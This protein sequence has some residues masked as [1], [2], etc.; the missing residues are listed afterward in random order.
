M[1]LVLSLSEPQFPHLSEY[2]G[3]YQGISPLALL[4]FGCREEETVVCH[5]ECFPVPLA[6]IQ[7]C[8]N[9][10]SLE[11]I[12]P[13]CMRAHTCACECYIFYGCFLCMCLVPL[14]CSTHRDQKRALGPLKLALIDGMSCHVGAE[15]QTQD[16]GRASGQH[17]HTGVCEYSP[18]LASNSQ[19]IACLCLY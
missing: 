18:W 17:S 10:E 4:P 13:T 15:N 16:S 2:L 11:K 5:S 3:F 6:S 12:T 8:I 19:R 1:T 9:S 14:L 7:H